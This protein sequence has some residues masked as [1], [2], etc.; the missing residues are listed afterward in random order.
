MSDKNKRAA[1]FTLASLVLIGCACSVE[2]G[3]PRNEPDSFM[4]R[5][6]LIPVRSMTF[7][8]SKNG[9]LPDH[10]KAEGIYA[11]VL[12]DA[13]I[14]GGFTPCVATDCNESASLEVEDHGLM[15]EITIKT[16]KISLSQL[17]DFSSGSPRP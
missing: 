3:A 4:T 13:L 5:R 14:S 15:A 6:L 1:L 8:M 9:L 7:E 17:W 12:K 10:M 11:S 2:G 16:S